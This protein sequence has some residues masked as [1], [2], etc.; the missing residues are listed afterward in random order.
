LRRYLQLAASRQQLLTI[1]RPDVMKT[2]PLV[3]HDHATWHENPGA[4][5]LGLDPATLGELGAG[6]PAGKQR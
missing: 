2:V 4:E 3:Q 5:L 1:V 6:S